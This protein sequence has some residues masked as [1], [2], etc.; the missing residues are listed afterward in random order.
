LKCSLLDIL[1]VLADFSRIAIDKVFDQQRDV[2]SSF[3]KGRHVNRENVQPINKSLR[4]DRALMAACRS[5]FVAAI[6]RTSSTNWTS[7][8]H[9]LKLMFLAK[10]AG[11]RSESQLEVL[12]L[13]RGKASLHLLVQTD[14]TAV[15]SRL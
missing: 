12:R 3:S 14:L 13:R 4:K 2:L 15:E 8:A 9:T 1:E 6:T 5:R 11:V 7:A 10:H